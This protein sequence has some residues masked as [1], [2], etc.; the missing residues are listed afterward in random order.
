MH[1]KAA[2]ACQVLRGRKKQ[3]TDARKATLQKKQANRRRVTSI[4]VFVKKWIFETPKNMSETA[5]G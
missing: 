1:E 4:L 3:Q 5:T 2:E